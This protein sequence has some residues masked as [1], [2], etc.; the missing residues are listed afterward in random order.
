[1]KV[2]TN[3]V[4]F[5]VT[6][7]TQ[8]AIQSSITTDSV[9][10]FVCVGALAVNVGVTPATYNIAGVTISG[11]DD[12]VVSAPVQVNLDATSFKVQLTVVATAP[13]CTGK[14][15]FTFGAN[16]MLIHR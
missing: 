7:A 13:S 1:M 8:V 9:Y 16:P 5:D 4:E 3:G 6:E 11:N 2:L 12:Y 14:F 15:R 10:G